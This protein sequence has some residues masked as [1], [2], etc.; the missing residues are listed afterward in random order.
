MALTFP[1]VPKDFLDL[2]PGATVHSVVWENPALG[3]F[4]II[5]PPPGTS[6]PQQCALP[7]GVPPPPTVRDAVVE[8]DTDLT[9]PIIPPEQRCNADGATPLCHHGVPTARLSS[10]GG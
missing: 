7:E 9:I 5:V 1:P 3:L 2:F 6:A 4:G 10:D 8:V